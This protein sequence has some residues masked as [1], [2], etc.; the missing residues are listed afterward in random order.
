MSVH[1]EEPGQRWVVRFRDSDRKQRSVTANALNF[2][3]YE[4]P[5][6][7]RIT[8][9]AVRRLEAEVLRRE[10]AADGSIRSA[11]RRKTMYLDVVA[12]HVPP[13]LSAEDKDTWEER[14]LGQPLE[15]ERTYS[16]LRVQHMILVLARYF[17]AYLD[18]GEI[19]WRRNGRRKHDRV[20]K[21]H[22][23]TRRID[24]IT[25]ENVAGFQI[26][27]T[28]NGLASATVRG[29]ITTLRS[30]F[31]WC[32]ER[33]YMVTNPAGGIKLPSRKKREIKWLEKKRV[34]ELLKAVR[35]HPLEG[36]VRT[37]LG[38][39]LRRT[40]MAHLEWPDLNFDIGI[41]RVR[42]T[43]TVKAYREVPLPVRLADYFKSL[44]HSHSSPRLL[45]NSNGEPWNKDSLNSSLRRFHA[46]KK[47]RFHWNFQM[48][49]ASYGSLLVQEGVPIAHV[50]IALGHADVRV[51][52]G[53]YIG[54]RATHI[55]PLI[56][57]AI[58]SVLTGG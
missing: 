51:T 23:C 16:N 18:T 33:G 7:E 20:A 52:Q 13:L 30:F 43:K 24:S 35:G 26:Y 10:T 48:L 5:V 25:R 22:A 6:P 19:R 32:T 1:W 8:R 14:P 44:P 17:P 21:V 41:V 29:Y 58:G 9:R 40:E 3:K 36:P 53:W 38:L 55:L 57:K 12:R 47:T 39:G 27:L 49:R 11:D 46:A 42:G 15:N 28:N 37:I 45:L 56:S 34:R 4:L 50:S 31:S 2:V 54:L